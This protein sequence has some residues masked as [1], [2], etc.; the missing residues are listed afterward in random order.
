MRDVVPAASASTSSSSRRPSS[1]DSFFEESTRSITAHKQS[2]TSIDE[3]FAFDSNEFLQDDGEFNF[4]DCSNDVS[5]DEMSLLLNDLDFDQSY[6]SSNLP[7]EPS[8]FTNLIND[9]CSL[10]VDPFHDYHIQ[11]ETSSRDSGKNSPSESSSEAASEY[12]PWSSTAGSSGYS[13]HYAE[14]P[15]IKPESFATQA[16]SDSNQTFYQGNP[17]HQISD[18][19]PFVHSQSQS[20]QFSRGQRF[21]LQSAPLQSPQPNLSPEQHSNV[22]TPFSS[23]LSVNS[24][25]FA[26]PA[27]IHA[28]KK[29]PPAVP[30]V[31]APGGKV[32]YLVGQA[33]TQPLL[34]ATPICSTPPVIV[35]TVQNAVCTPSTPKPTANSA[36]V[37][38][39]SPVQNTRKPAVL[40]QISPPPKSAFVPADPKEVELQRRQEDR[41]IRNRASAQASR[42]RKKNE[43]DE[44]KTAI[45]NLEEENAKLKTENQELKER[46][47]QYEN[48]A[49]EDFDVERPFIEEAHCNP[50]SRKRRALVAGSCLMAICLLI[51][52][53]INLGGYGNVSRAASPKEAPS[54][55]VTNHGRV[56]VADEDY[57]VPDDMQGNG[58]DNITNGVGCNGQYGAW[59]NKSETMR[60]NMDLYNWVERHEQLSD[61]KRIRRGKK[62]QLR[63]RKESEEWKMKMNQ[64]ERVDMN[65]SETFEY[66]GN[67][68]MKVMANKGAP[69][70]YL[71]NDKNVRRTVDEKKAEAKEQA[72]RDRAWK[73]LDMISQTSESLREKREKA[74]RY[75]KWEK[76]WE[77]RQILEKQQSGLPPVNRP[78]KEQFEKLTALVQQ[79]QD[80]LYM[81]TMKEYLL[82]PAMER[83]ATSRPKLSIIM[84]AH[85]WNG[86]MTDQI[87]LMRIECDVVGTGLFNL[88]DA[89]L[90][91]FFN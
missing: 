78:T 86:T 4:V 17:Q 26:K 27:P 7:S 73:H 2:T 62:V 30:S 14:Q 83:N 19:G 34:F 50:P 29:S 58:L 49:V 51:A 61:V 48:Q 9:D 74:R 44:M 15:C 37:F 21:I 36:A 60:L 8:N 41:K 53:P 76:E 25:N 28:Q 45:I 52:M 24:A 46:L 80:T 13:P 79:R 23:P 42:I 6:P 65:A 90:S 39:T 40:Q 54:R 56:V 1:E 59:L 69:A 43:Y 12:S 22:P 10:S 66:T 35:K 16:G 5:P 84:P 57:A 33:T 77:A 85:S 64:T 3:L 70:A 75:A 87:P 72:A 32:L 38:A 82:F 88:S 31:S 81:I 47:A 63:P 55:S 71:K 11:T 91:I 89:F 67:A 18:S 68:K 20:A